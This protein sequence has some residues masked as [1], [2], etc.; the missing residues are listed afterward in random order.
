VIDL[1]REHVE[2]VPP[3][4][5]TPFMSFNETRAPGAK[6][7]PADTWRAVLPEN[8]YE[9]LMRFHIDRGVT[10]RFNARSKMDVTVQEVML[11]HA[12][13]VGLMGTAGQH[14]RTETRAEASD[15]LR[16]HFREAITEYNA[17]V[18]PERQ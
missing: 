4:A 9:D 10:F 12:M 15:L 16:D 3:A 13:R 2:W 6:V 18:S 14:R 7:S 1:S 8:F 17:T 5:R 11:Y